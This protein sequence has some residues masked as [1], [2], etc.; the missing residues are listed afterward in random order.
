MAFGN[1]VSRS[2]WFENSYWDSKTHF[3]TDKNNLLIQ[4]CNLLI[5]KCM[6]HYEFKKTFFK[7]Q[8]FHIDNIWIERSFGSF[9]PIFAIQ[10]KSLA[11]SS[12]FI[13]KKSSLVKNQGNFGNSSHSTDNDT[14]TAIQM[15]WYH[16]LW[17]FTHFQDIKHLVGIAFLENS[18]FYA[19]EFDW[20]PSSLINTIPIKTELTQ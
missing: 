20:K 15:D 4:K 11:F 14:I 5:R 12:I 1:S 19:F 2:T 8:Q 6:D 18:W 13:Q 3:V 16:K 10:G 7:G 17:P 9:S